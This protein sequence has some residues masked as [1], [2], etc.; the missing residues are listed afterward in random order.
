MK[1]RQILTLL[2][3]LV[4]GTACSSDSTS[5]VVVEELSL[6]KKSFLF[7]D[8][9]SL[10]FEVTLL[11]SDVKVEPE[12]F[13]LTNVETNAPS[14]C[15]GM[16]FSSQDGNKCKM[17]LTDL[18]PGH[19][20]NETLELTYDN[21]VS[22][23]L[24]V[25]N[26]TRMPAVYVTCSTPISGHT[27]EDW[28]PATIR[29]DGGNILPDLA[30]METEIRGRGNTTWGWKK[31]PFALKLSKK[32]EVLG[33]PK[34]KRWCLIANHMDRTHMRNRVAYYLGANS[35]LAYTT[36]NEYAEFYYN[37]VYQG[38]YLVTEQIKIDENRVNIPELETGDTG[39]AA[40]GGY[41]L[42]FDTNY[43]E[44]KRF[45]SST[46]YI[47]INLKGPDAED[48]SDEQWRYIQEYVNSADLAVFNNSKPFDYL[49]MT[50]LIDYWI[51]FEVTANHEVLHPKSIYFHKDRGGKLAA[52]PIWD[53]D[54]Q[55][56]IQAT[57][58][59]WINYN[60]SYAYN[61]YPWYENNWWNLLIKQ[62]SEFKAALK[63]RWQEWYPFLQT[64]PAF[65]EQERE[66]ISEAAA[67]NLTKW[68]EID[69]TGYVNGDERLSFDAAVDRLKSVY[70]TRLNWMNNEISR[71]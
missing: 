42:E 32:Q 36:R 59:S 15:V 67:R 3:A 4:L 44:D 10:S 7:D 9:Q 64:I 69:D 16:R 60:L 65:I 35:K 71:W 27:K 12:C 22:A 57:Q 30:E 18:R 24:T 29:I 39:E 34:H 54:Y 68:P 26:K 63:Q 13:T 50:S 62:N 2:L 20:Y 5:E 11:P 41:L 56:L 48:I 45:R 17:V 28:Q 53:F 1:T 14:E 47:P 58:T 37:D 46:T 33:M 55:T 31:K 8:G 23:T 49:D 66:K 40:T 70:S 25:A 43:D 6:S 21:K 61:E 52:G 51:I 38:L 19:V